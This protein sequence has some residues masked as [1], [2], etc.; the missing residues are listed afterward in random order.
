[1]KSKVVTSFLM[2]IYKILKTSPD[3]VRY[4]EIKGEELIS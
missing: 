4:L 3:A 1:M 2:T